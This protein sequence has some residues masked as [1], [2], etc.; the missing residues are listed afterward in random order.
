M[1]KPEY[2]CQHFS[3]PMPQSVLAA[4]ALVV[5]MLSSGV[6]SLARHCASVIGTEPKQMCKAGLPAT[7]LNNVLVGWWQSQHQNQ[8]FVADQ[9]RESSSVLSRLPLLRLL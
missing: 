1:Q 4:L 5:P 6:P 7:V 8:N 9:T 3:L 2:S